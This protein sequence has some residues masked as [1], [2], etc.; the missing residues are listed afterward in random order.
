MANPLKK[1]PR[2]S[3]RKPDT[4]IKNTRDEKGNKSHSIKNAWRKVTAFIKDGER[5]SL[6][7]FARA[8]A[9]TPEDSDLKA[10]AQRWLYNKLANTSKPSLGIGSTRKKT[11][12]NAPKKKSPGDSSTDDGKSAVKRGSFR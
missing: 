7:A 12:P 1:S 3:N 2:P 10:S 9:A 8:M 11:Q 4:V 5:P 6:R